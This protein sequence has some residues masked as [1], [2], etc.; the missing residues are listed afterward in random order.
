QEAEVETPARDCDVAREA[1]HDPADLAGALF[2]EDAQDV[3]VRVAAVKQHRLADVT[4]EREQPAEDA[5]LSVAGR[6]VPKE[7]ETDFAHGDDAGLPRQRRDLGK[8]RLV[9]VTG[10]VRM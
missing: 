3:L 6:E 1:V 7:I 2:G 8:R 10:V 4:A 5:L 9:G